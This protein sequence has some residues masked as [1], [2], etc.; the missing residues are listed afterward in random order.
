MADLRPP[1]GDFEPLGDI[2]AD[3]ARVLDLQRQLKTALEF[4]QSLLNKEH[5]NAPNLA[6]GLGREKRD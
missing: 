5:K 1:S 4:E 3:D 6:I 2:S